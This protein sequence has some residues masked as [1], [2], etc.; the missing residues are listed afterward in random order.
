MCKTHRIKKMTFH[1]LDEKPRWRL[2]CPDIKKS[3][4]SLRQAQ[5]AENFPPKHIT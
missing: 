5:K 4:Y 1:R 2:N 3:G